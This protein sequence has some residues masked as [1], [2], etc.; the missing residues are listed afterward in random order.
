MN[1]KRIGITLSIIII[2]FAFVYYVF[3]IPLVILFI[4]QL[5]NKHNNY[6]NDV[7]CPKC[8]RILTKGKQKI[9]ISRRKDDV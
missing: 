2:I 4:L 3:T 9:V 7:V 8:R 6:N 1:W 5:Y